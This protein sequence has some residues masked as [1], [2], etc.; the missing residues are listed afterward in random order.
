MKQIHA[1]EREQFEKLFRQ[2]AI[3]RL[4]D[5]FLVLDAFLLNEA[6]VTSEGLE[7]YIR[8]QGYELTA[9]FVSETLELMCHFGFAQKNRFKN[10]VQHYEHRHLGQHH[11]HMICT[12]CGDIVE[13]ENRKLEALQHRIAEDY[14]FYMLQHQMEIYGICN[15]CQAER[16]KKMSLVLAKPGE[17][18]VIRN[19]IGGNSSR[20]RLMS[21][22]LRVGDKI[23]ILTNSGK[24]QLVVV[25]DGQRY[26]LG[27]GLAQKIIVEQAGMQNK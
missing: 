16:A 3:D 13:F 23:E 21:M 4:E 7:A 1:I 15:Q 20:L 22:G 26:V 10:G 2:E 8:E 18:L 25:A 9:E 27:R 6:H 19:L 24:G 11:D 14:G 12:K 17:L 5:R